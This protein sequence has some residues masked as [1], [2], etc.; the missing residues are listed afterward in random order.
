MID[1]ITRYGT[2]SIAKEEKNQKTDFMPVLGIY[3][4]CSTIKA[5]SGS[6][7]YIFIVI[8]GKNDGQN[9]KIRNFTPT[10]RNA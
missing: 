8:K 3:S 4:M 1:K 5:H 10:E 6:G 2:L 9:C 7:D